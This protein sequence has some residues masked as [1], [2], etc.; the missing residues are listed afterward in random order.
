MRSS[1]RPLARPTA[2]SFLRPSVRPPAR[3]SV[4]MYL[5]DRL[6]AAGAGLGLCGPFGW[7]GG[8][9]DGQGRHQPSAT[10]SAVISRRRVC[11][12]FPVRSSK[13][14]VA[15]KF[16][17]DGRASWHHRDAA[18]RGPGRPERHC[19]AVCWI[20]MSDNRGRQLEP[21]QH[22]GRVWAAAPTHPSGARGLRRRKCRGASSLGAPILPQRCSVFAPLRWASNLSDI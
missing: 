13:Q 12:P 6:A 4:T 16:D 10:A 18:R 2:R 7:V 5:T 11:R 9:T 8:L 17:S 14:A 22:E 20:F 3:E 21:C 1:V 19:W 15:G